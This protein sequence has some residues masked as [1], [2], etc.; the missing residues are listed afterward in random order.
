MII[1]RDENKNVE[2]QKTRWI[3]FE[4]VLL[5]LEEKRIL[6]AW[7]HPNTAKYSHQKAFVV[8]IDDYAYLVPYIADND[9]I[10]L[11][12]IY[13]SRKLTKKFLNK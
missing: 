10:F 5:A 3:S 9:K 4:D 2:L 7:S 13:P 8:Q 11:K 1:D 6:Y 12:M